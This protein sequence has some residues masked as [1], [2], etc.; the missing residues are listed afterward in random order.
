MKITP[1]AGA[2]TPIGESTLGS[3]RSA[4]KLAAA[5]AIA[6]GQLPPAPVERS[7][8]VTDPQVRR[9]R[10]NVQRSTDRREAPPEA[11]HWPRLT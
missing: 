5:K 9:I 3:G 4:D 1:N 8:I 7:E 10:M 11:R 6:A 2:G